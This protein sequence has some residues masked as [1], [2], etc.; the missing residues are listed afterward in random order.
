MG[1]RLA[2]VQLHVLWDEILRRDLA[3]EVMGPPRRLYSNFI[4]GFRAL[5][6]RIAG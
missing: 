1:D 5:P 4:R 6:A 2:E 3:I